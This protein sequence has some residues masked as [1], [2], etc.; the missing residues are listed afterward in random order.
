MAALGPLFLYLL[1]SLILTLSSAQQGGWLAD[2]CLYGTGNFTTNSTYH[3]NRNRLLS[4]FTSISENDYGF[5][6]VSSVGRNPDQ[7]N[8]IALCRGDVKPD[9]C[10]GCIK[11]AAIEIKNSCLTKEAAQFYD[12][13]M[14]RYSNN[15]ILGVQDNNGN[16]FRWPEGAIAADVSAFSD[17]LT[18]LLDRLRGRAAA[19]G[20]LQKFAAGMTMARPVDSIYA[21]VQCTPDLSQLQ[22]SSCLSQAFER[23]PKCCLGR[24][25][26][27]IFGPSCIVR[28]DDSLFYNDSSADIGESPPPLSLLS[29]PPLSLTPP[30]NDSSSPSTLTITVISISSSILLISICICIFVR[31]RKSKKK[32]EKAE[33]VAEIES[34]ETLQYD[35][36]TIRDATNNFSDENKLGQG[37]FG[38]VYKGTLANGQEVAVKRLSM[39][40]GQGDLEFKNEVQLVAR[41]QHRNLVKVHGFCLEGRERLLIYE[42]VPNSSLDR[43]LFDPIKCTQLSWE[44][45]YKIIGGTAKGILYLHEDSRFP[46]IH[47]NLKASNV[48]LDEEMNPKISDFGIARLFVVDQTQD[49]T[50]KSVGTYGYIAPE[51]AVEGQLSIKTDVYSFGVL[52]LEIVSGQKINYIH[53]EENLASLI[54]DAWRNWREGTPLN[55]VDPRLSTGSSAEIIRCIHIGLLCVQEN[56]AKRPTMGSIVVMLTSYSLTLPMPSHP[57]FFMYSA[58]QSNMLSSQSFNLEGTKL[59]KSRNENATASINE[60][61]ITKLH[62]R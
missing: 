3:T 21:L 48:L 57:S 61:S 49:A 8:G 10:L 40:S 45:R 26:G 31:V 53:H 39:N 33:A 41:L 1:I 62:P 25:G 35:L 52:I 6:N 37:G 13:C 27:K 60:V 24:R 51:Y 38:A 32:F 17:A 46:I 29:P 9:V 59:Q 14:L 58:T 42:F 43:F 16:F 54:S 34:V 20:S 12:N 15:S 55:I 36:S 4:S 50:S 19:G 11:D 18:S 7:V 56:V 30:S 44:T 22:C 23:I 5:Y 2:P 28:F 47:R